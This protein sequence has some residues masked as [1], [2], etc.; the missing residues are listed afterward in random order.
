M[1]ATDL[2]NTAPVWQVFR[3]DGKPRT[4]VQLPAPPPWRVFGI[5][6]SQP[7]AHVVYRAYPRLI[8]AV[9]VSIALRRPLLLTGPAGMGKSS[10]A[11]AIA[12]ELGVGEPLRWNVTSRSTVEEALYRYDALGRLRHQQLKE[13]ED[14][15]EKFLRLG[16]VGTALASAR[17][18]V[19][20][21]DELDKGDIDLPGDLLNLLE[22]GEFEIPELAR[23][24]VPE[25]A[26][27]ESDSD[28]VIPI[29]EGQV[30]SRN[31][32]IVVITSNGER[33]FAPAFLRRCIRERIEIPGADRLAEIVEA[34]LGPELTTRAHLLIE[35]FARRIGAAERP[36]ALAIDQL[37]N[38]VL[39]MTRDDAPADEAA[40]QEL[41]ELLQRELRDS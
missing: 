17:Q 26:I 9:N 24:E 30:S 27:R 7:D 29:V 37:L 32:P 39:L 22:R 40:R 31:F 16:P 34:H 8:S 3:G 25:M 35:D 5:E 41:V 1:P 36:A 19:L 6:R 15:L 38:T 18:R 21:I 14:A 13:T 20:L 2:P 12:Y 11:D 4:V 28:V 33:E 23:H 10:V